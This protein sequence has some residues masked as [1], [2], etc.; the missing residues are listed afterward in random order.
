MDVIKPFLFS[1]SRILTHFEIIK[2]KRLYF[3]TATVSNRN[4]VKKYMFETVHL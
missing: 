3:E 1:L 2:L 4:L